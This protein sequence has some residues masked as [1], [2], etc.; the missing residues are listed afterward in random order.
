LTYCSFM[1]IFAEIEVP[2]HLQFYGKGHKMVEF[3]LFFEF[4]PE[5]DQIH[6]NKFY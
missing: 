6:V 1:R 2:Y 3:G 4:E 5:N